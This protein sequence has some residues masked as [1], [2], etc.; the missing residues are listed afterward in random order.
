M[1]KNLHKK[2]GLISI[3][4]IMLS[5]TDAHAAIHTFINK[6]GYKAWIKVNYLGHI[7]NFS[8]RP[9]IFVLENNGIHR[10]NTKSCLISNIESKIYI[11]MPGLPDAIAHG[12]AYRHQTTTLEQVVFILNRM[13]DQPGYFFAIQSNS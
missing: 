6:S 4:V 2:L 13:A 7:K 3:L 9:D 10:F 12:E 1:K 5:I 8:C 11:P